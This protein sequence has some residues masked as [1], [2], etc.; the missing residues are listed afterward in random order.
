MVTKNIYTNC[1]FAKKLLT[2]LM[3][4]AIVWAMVRLLLIIIINAI[5]I[6]DTM[7]IV[8]QTLSHFIS[9]FVDIFKVISIILIAHLLLL[10]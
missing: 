6:G 2:E 1:F 3:V 5:S 10:W 7:Q 8:I 9:F 4:K